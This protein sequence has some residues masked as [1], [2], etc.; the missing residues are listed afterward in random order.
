MNPNWKRW[1]GNKE[2]DFEQDG[3]AESEWNFRKD[4]LQNL[5]EKARAL[6]DVV[7]FVKIYDRNAMKKVIP[8]FDVVYGM[9]KH[10]L[11]E[12]FKTYSKKIE[13]AFFLANYFYKEV[14]RWIHSEQCN[15]TDDV[16]EF[17]KAIEYLYD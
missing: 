11:Q 3:K 6:Q 4:E 13:K 10:P 12:H 16:V 5:A 14:F 8:M 17:I 2:S 9:I 1:E 7:G 15:I